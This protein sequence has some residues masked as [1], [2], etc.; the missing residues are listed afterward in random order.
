MGDVLPDVDAGQI[1]DLFNGLFSEPYSGAVDDLVIG[2][3]ITD[4][5]GPGGVLG[6]AGPIFV[7][8]DDIGR[9][10]AP[11]SGVMRFDIADVSQMPI[12]DFTLVV[13]HEIGHILGLVGTTTT[14]CN[15]GCNRFNGEQSGYSCPLANAEYDKLEQRV[16]PKLTLEN[17]GGGGTACGHWEEDAFRSGE[18]SE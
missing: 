2:F 1:P 10:L 11:V 13:Q 14:R 15:S 8:Q 17:N 3:E 18:S 4:I 9:P 7:R 16:L 12:E 6:A 5:D